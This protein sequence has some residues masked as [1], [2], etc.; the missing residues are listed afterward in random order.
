M[1]SKFLD[2]DKTYHH[3]DLI[4]AKK[5]LLQMLGNKFITNFKL[6]YDNE[7]KRRFQFGRVFDESNNTINGIIIEIDTPTKFFNTDTSDYRESSQK[8]DYEKMSR[9]ILNKFIILRIFIDDLNTPICIDKINKLKHITNTCSIYKSFDWIPSKLASVQNVYE[10]YEKYLK[11]I[12][13]Y[14]DNECNLDIYFKKPCILNYPTEPIDKIQIINESN[15]IEEQKTINKSEPKVKKPQTKDENFLFAWLNKNYPNL[16]EPQFTADWAKKKAK[17]RYD[18]VSQQHKLIIELDGGSHFRVIPLFR[19]NK[20]KLI[21]IQ[22]DDMNKNKL[23]I[24]NGYK[25]IRLCQDYIDDRNKYDWENI[26]KYIIDNIIN[27]SITDKFIPFPS[28][29]DKVNETYHIYYHRLFVQKLVRPYSNI[30][31]DLLF[32]NIHKMNKKRDN[33]SGETIEVINEEI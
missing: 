24:I 9:A 1:T 2:Y 27:N 4:N 16:F 14:N 12:T 13:N 22:N 15:V 17:L 31:V 7:S 8:N 5:Q 29:N 3:D 11:N 23:A 32:N 30:I 33:D 6:P 10:S 25:I 26:L 21:E 18:F 19:M 20:N 28:P